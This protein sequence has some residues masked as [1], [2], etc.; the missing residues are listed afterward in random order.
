MD[1]VMAWRNV[2]RNPRRSLLTMAAIA[3]ATLLLVFMLSMQFGSYETMIN[4]AVKIQTGHLQVQA[5]TYQEKRDIR[6]VV[7]DPERIAKILEKIPQVTAFTFR[8]EAFVLVSS[9]DRTYGAMLVGVDPQREAGVST[10]KTIVRQGRY[11]EPSDTNQALLGTLLA[12]NL[13]VDVGDE[14][15]ILGQGRDGSIA[16]TVVTLKGIFNSGQDDFDRSV[17]HVPLPFFQETFG[18]RGAVHTVVAISKSLEAVPGIKQ[19]VNDAL[20]RLPLND[21]LVALDWQELLPG[22]IQA[23]KMDL[24]S[25]F[26]F[27]II[28]IIVV[29]FSILNTFLMAIFERTREFGVMM[30][31]GTRPGRLV[32][33]ILLESAGITLLGSIAGI[34]AGCLITWYFQV[35][36]IL[37]PGAE[38]VARQFGLPERIYPNLSVFSVGIGAGIVLVITSMTALYPALR[39]RRLKPVDALTAT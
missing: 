18:M 20:K 26:I 34:L 14:L 22:L 28:L 32:K 19:A 11:L 35:H 16:A 10:L 38:E 2:W 30:A 23:I 13:R 6:L 9:R 36:G 24:V 29:A 27:Y 4:S 12:R 25:G 39:V 37:I 21:H 31:I 15:V 33:L 17:V 3:F 5:Q 1:L 7:P 8:S